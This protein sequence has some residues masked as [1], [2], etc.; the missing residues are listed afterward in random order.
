MVVD[1]FYVGCVAAVPIKA[2][3]ELVIYSDAVLPPTISR[4]GFEVVAQWYAQV[5]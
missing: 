3:P 4:K 1:D 5:V 2:D